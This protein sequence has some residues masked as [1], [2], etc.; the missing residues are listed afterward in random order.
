MTPCALCGAGGASARFA[1]AGGTYVA[2]DECGLLRLDPLPSVDEA[3]A[4]YGAGYFEEGDDGGYAGYDRAEAAH[5]HNASAHLDRI[6]ALGASSG[7]LVEIGC[8]T[9]WLLIEAQHRG[10]DVSGVEVSDHARQLAAARAGT[11]I[12]P[13]IAD[14]DASIEPGSVDV[15]VAVQVLEHLVDPA[16][17]L[18]TFARWLRPGGVLLVET[19]DAG[20]ATA[21]AFG[22]RWQQ[23]TPP[24]VIWLF[25]RR[26]LPHLLRDAGFDAVSLRATSKRVGVGSVLELLASKAPR[27]AGPLRRLGDRAGVAGAVVPYRLGDL[28]TATAFRR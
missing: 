5:R 16:D 22:A 6:E 26:T 27:V 18:A 10:F 1:V 12:A 21:R 2:C 4:L 3:A 9:G 13:S 19:W 8:A 28:V 15:V 7:R 24:S 23:L 25:D 14:A 11:E 17:A 20:S